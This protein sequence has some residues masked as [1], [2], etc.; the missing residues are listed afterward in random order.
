MLSFT[1]SPHPPTTRL[2]QTH[3]LITPQD[4]QT[5]GKNEERWRAFFLE[6]KIQHFDN[7]VRSSDACAPLPYTPDP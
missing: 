3:V 1:P 7:V 5:G 6:R 2:A 4:D